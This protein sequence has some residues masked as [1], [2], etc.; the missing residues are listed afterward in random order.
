METYSNLMKEIRDGRFVFT[1][2]LEPVKT[3]DVSE[4]IEEA[5]SLKGY[6]VA[7]NVTD[8]PASYA[9]MS[10]LVAS[11]LVQ[12]QTG[13]EVIYQLRCSDRNRIA[14]TS[15][16]LGAAALGIK[17]VLALTGDHTILGDMPDAKPVFDLDSVLLTGMIRRMVTEGKDLQG[18]PIQGAKPQF[19][20]GVAANP[21]ADP[22]EL[23]L[24]KVMKKVQN[25]ADFIQTQVCF[26][27]EKTLS[28][29]EMAKTLERPILI[30]I[31]PMKSYAMAQGFN[32][33]VPGVKVPTELMAK[34]KAIKDG[35]G[36]R[37]EKRRLYDEVNLDF[38]VPFIKELKR[39]GLCAGC[40][41]MS[42]H[43][44]EITPKL[45]KEI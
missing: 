15:D 16:L 5:K 45:V 18:N 41:I 3:T 12:S 26:D 20:I 43:Y 34:L 23:E 4:V 30:G 36:S 44:T 9:S 17:N 14:L 39:S 22:L 37:D 13:M 28:F 35:P 25:G 7:C 32:Q 38:F 6:V 40:H 11:Y 42:V 8:N 31:F 19:H 24:A 2:E 27:K 21:N 29:L 33:L 10:S 1:G